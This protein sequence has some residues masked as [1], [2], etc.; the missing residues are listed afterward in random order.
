MKECLQALEQFQLYII[1]EKG[2]AKNSSDAYGRDIR[3]FI[4]YLESLSITSF[5]AISSQ[6]I[7]DFLAQL[8]DRGYASASICRALIALKVFFL[9]LKREN[10]LPVNLALHLDSPKL[11]Q[12][13]PEVLSYVEVELLLK[14]PNVNTRLGARDRAILEVLYGCGLRVSE[15]CSLELYHVDNEFIA[16]M[17]KGRKE[18]KVPIGK[19]AINAID[20]YLTHHRGVAAQNDRHQPLFITERGKGMDRVAIW[21]MIKRYVTHAGIAKNVSPHSLRHSFATHLLDNGADLRI[22]QELLGH[23]SISSTDRYT[24]VSRV[25]LQR[26]FNAFHP[27]QIGE[28]AKK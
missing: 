9:F 11:W 18:R 13:I 12:T 17:G 10:H 21:R 27:R 14:Q 3:A 6:Q 7:I 4:L 25:H 16:V 8:H 24:H 15:V 20:H 26:S 5:H 22:I 19:S 2:L 23:A 28:E 1:S